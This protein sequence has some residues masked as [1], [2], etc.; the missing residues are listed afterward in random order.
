M[1][2]RVSI[3]SFSKKNIR[4]SLVDLY[5]YFRRGEFDIFFA[6][7]WP[8]TIIALIMKLFFKEKKVVVIEHCDIFA[9][10]EYKN[11]LFKKERG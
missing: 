10:V 6:N 3:K 1:N 4:S 7:I 11:N 2:E 5:K 8:L 9:E